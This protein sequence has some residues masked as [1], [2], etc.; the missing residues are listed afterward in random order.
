MG[1]KLFLVQ[2]SAASVTTLALLAGLWFLFGIEKVSLATMA[3]MAF[4]GFWMLFMGMTGWMPI[5]LVLPPVACQRMFELTRKLDKSIQE[6]DELLGY[7][8]EL[9]ELAKADETSKLLLSQA[10]DSHS[11]LSNA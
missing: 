10:E 7:Q 9:G 5:R 3:L 6:L 4:M 11:Q 8:L 1:K 2:T